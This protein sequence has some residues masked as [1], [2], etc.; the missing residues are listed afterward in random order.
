MAIEQK[1]KVVQYLRVLL[2]ELQ[3][4]HE[5]LLGNVRKSLAFESHTEQVMSFS[6]IGVLRCGE[7]QLRDRFIQ[8]PWFSKSRPCSRCSEPL[9]FVGGAAV[10]GTEMASSIRVTR[11][12]SNF[13]T[14]FSVSRSN[15]FCSSSPPE[16]PADCLERSFQSSHKFV[17]TAVLRTT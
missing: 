2:V 4:R 1:P 12:E 14:S 5:R 9:K 15:L 3:R 16:Q 13:L 11:A 7:G 8:I 17:T 6:E 10:A